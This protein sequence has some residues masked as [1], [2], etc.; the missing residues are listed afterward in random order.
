MPHQ[1]QGRAEQKPWWWLLLLPTA[2]PPLDRNNWKQWPLR[3]VAVTSPPVG[4][5]GLWAWPAGLLSGKSE[6]AFVSAWCASQIIL[7][8]CPIN[9]HVNQCNWERNSLSYTESKPLNWWQGLS[10][11]KHRKCSPLKDVHFLIVNLASCSLSYHWEE[12][13]GVILY[14]WAWNG[15]HLCPV[16]LCWKTNC[17]HGKSKPVWIYSFQALDSLCIF[18]ILQYLSTWKLSF[19]SPWSIYFI[20]ILLSACF[21]APSIFVKNEE[22]SM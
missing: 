7:H 3:P 4:V 6:T 5:L 14:F 2:L 15:G 22:H 10:C 20:H 8:Q 12:Q 11:L 9:A 17:Q 19:I 21:L 18:F 13:W 16:Y 1:Q